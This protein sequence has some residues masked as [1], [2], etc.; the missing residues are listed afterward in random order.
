MPDPTIE[1]RV[2]ALGKAL[3]NTVERWGR[4]AQA[5]NPAGAAAA[6]VNA[7][8]QVVRAILRMTARVIDLLKRVVAQLPDF[9]ADTLADVTEMLVEEVSQLLDDLANL[10]GAAL[11]AGL[12][13]VLG[14]IEVVKKTIY[15]IT[16]YIDRTVGKNPLTDLIRLHLDILNNLLGHAA[17]L[18]SPKTGQVARRMRLDMYDQLAAI[19]IAEG[20]IALRSIPDP[21]SE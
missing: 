5:A 18:V 10:A 8:Q 11:E 16:D 19:R 1:E 9:F 13:A 2:D 6:G 3:A 14:F 12:G 20:A 4:F 15:L 17:E 7:I 21:E